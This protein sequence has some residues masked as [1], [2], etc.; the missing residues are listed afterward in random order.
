VYG[1]DINNDGTATNDLLYVPTDGEIDNMVFIPLIDALGNPQD[2]DAQRQAFKQFIRQDDYL[3]GLRGQ[4][5][6]KYG[7]ETH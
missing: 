3:S 5:T 4:Y 6:E 1:G 7:E 2:E